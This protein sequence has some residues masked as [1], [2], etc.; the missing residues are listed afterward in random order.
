MQNKN[1]RFLVQKVRIL[2]QQSIKPSWGPG[3]YTDHMPAYKVSPLEPT[4]SVLGTILGT[5]SK[6]VGF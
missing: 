2:R 6:A 5:E 3:D 1:T 4:D